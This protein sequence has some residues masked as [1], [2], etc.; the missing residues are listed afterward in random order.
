MTSISG[1]SPT[2]LSPRVFIRTH[3]KAQLLLSA[4]LIAVLLLAFNYSSA[5]ATFDDELQALWK[6]DDGSGGTA[7]DSSGNDNHGTLNGDFLWTTEGIGGSLNLNGDG[8]YVTVGVGSQYSDL[9]ING[10]SFGG[11]INPNGQPA[12]SRTYGIIGRYDYT[13]AD[14]F[15]RL[16]YN[17]WGRLFAFISYDGT[18]TNRCRA[19][20]GY[21]F[22]FDRW[23][24]VFVVFDGSTLKLYLDGVEEGSADC[25]FVGIDAAAWQDSESTFLGAFDSSDTQGEINAALDEIAMFNR[26]LSPAELLDI[27]TNGVDAAP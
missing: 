22:A 26:A 6:L 10:C 21:D 17:R 13:D 2:V 15:F 9:C 14:M 3:R 5:A 4:I 25:G 27:Y 11:W 24:H 8:D 7:L 16:A 12:A 19:T 20:S 1:L 23:Q 18:V